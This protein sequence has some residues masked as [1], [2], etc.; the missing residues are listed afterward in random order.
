MIKISVIIPTWM[1]ATE[2]EI[3]CNSLCSQSFNFSDFEVIICD[4]N[5]DDNTSGV[6]KKFE[7]KL[8]IIYH[9]S[10]INAISVKR[11]DGARIA[12]G[13]ILV[14]LDDDVIPSSQLL[15]I[16]YNKH[17]ETTEKVLMGLS[18]FSLLKENKSNFIKYRNRRSLRVLKFG[19]DV[20]S[21]N[22]VSMNFSIKK[23]DFFKI[24]LFDENFVNYG[25]EDHDF[26]CRMKELGYKSVMLSDARSEH[27]EPSP[28]LI[29][30]MKKI[31]VS[32]R[33]GFVP[34]KNKF[35][36]F[37]NNSSLR[38]LEEYEDN[39]SFFSIGRIFTLF[40][41]NKYVIKNIISYLLWSDSKPLFYFPIFYRVVFAAAYF[42]GVKDRKS[43]NNNDEPYFM[44][45]SK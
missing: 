38:L 45:L 5:S 11:N 31:Y 15:E 19:N 37:F 7:N 34:L 16:Y 10:K 25:G 32:A 41:L 40:I 35:P 39:K 26:P 27:I 28:N 23:T 43:D 3:L 18:L 13:N 42:E 14:F 9:H 36:N 1:R 24:G 12:S 29:N 30:R 4:S 33:Y 21:N 20:S 2:L 22:F 8:N 17:K 6:V 44:K